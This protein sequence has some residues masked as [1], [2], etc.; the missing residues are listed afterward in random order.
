MAQYMSA[1]PASDRPP[2]Y[3]LEISAR[4]WR[5][6]FAD[7]LRNAGQ[8]NLGLVAAGVAFFAL[9]AVF[10]SLAAVVVL[11]GLFGDPGGVSAQIDALEGIAPGPVL[12][13]AREQM[14]RLI[15]A[16]ASIL[17]FNGLVSLLIALWSAQQGARSFLHAL[18]IINEHTTRRSFLKRYLIGGAFTFGALAMALITVYLFTLAPHVLDA[19]SSDSAVLMSVL[20]WPVLFAL[21]TAFALGLYR[22][23][24]NRKPPAWRWIAPGAL[25]ASTSWLIVSA[26]FS[27]YVDMF[28]PFRAAYGVLSGVFVLMLWF[29]LS[30]WLFLFGAEINARMERLCHLLGDEESEPS[31]PSRSRI[32]SADPLPA[33]RR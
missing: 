1:E 12:D 33:E 18:T 24:P 26:L 5:A 23:G 3:L 11:Y 22:W 4:Q 25:F 21:M 20:R 8:D 10:P 30:A 14:S 19:V 6:L 9:L 31:S 15:H 32:S 28:T 13:I 2:S 29:F 17:A 16:D 27:A 7:A